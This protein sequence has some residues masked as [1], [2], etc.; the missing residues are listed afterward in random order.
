MFPLVGG[1]GGT[2]KTDQHFSYLSL[3]FC[4]TH[5]TFFPASSFRRLFYALSR[6]LT[7]FPP[8]V[9]SLSGL[10]TLAK[11]TRLCRRRLKW[12]VVRTSRLHL[13]SRPFPVLRL[14]RPLP[15]LPCSAIDSFC[16]TPN[17]MWQRLRDGI[18]REG[19]RA[20][21]RPWHERKGSRSQVRKV[22]KNVTDIC[23]PPVSLADCICRLMS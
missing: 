4:Y 21:H 10:A 15:I 23:S 7:S 5:P 16:M 20:R 3:C 6:F 12:F 17:K 9:S 2:R 19:R 1:G 14:A 13:N 18:K 22:E 11:V 8:Q